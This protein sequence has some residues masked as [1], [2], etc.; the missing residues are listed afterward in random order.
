MHC[1]KREAAKLK[2]INYIIFYSLLYSLALHSVLP[3]Y[4][5]IQ[6]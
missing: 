3:E 2:L 5:D 4:K 1:K 6:R